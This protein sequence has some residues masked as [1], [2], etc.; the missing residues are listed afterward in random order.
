[1]AFPHDICNIICD[2]AAVYVVT[3][4]FIYHTEPD[5]HK[6]SGNTHTWAR[7]KLHANLK[8]I[9]WKYLSSNS[10]TWACD[11][12]KSN[13]EKIDW[14]FLSHNT[15]QWACD[16][17]RKNM[18]MVDFDHLEIATVV[19]KT[20]FDFHSELGD[21]KNIQFSWD[22]SYEPLVAIMKEI[23]EVTPEK[24]GWNELFANPHPW[25]IALAKENMESL[26]TSEYI[27]NPHPDVVKVLEVLV[28]AL[29]NIDRSEFK[30]GMLAINPNPQVLKIFSKYAQHKREEKYIW[31][32]PNIFMEDMDRRYYIKRILIHLNQPDHVYW[33]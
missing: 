1:M 16:H 3:Y 28:P 18:Q 22:S 8:R 7:D 6:L 12:L 25:A 29:I 23:A 20:S 30:W 31:W 2:Y 27:A 10:S 11:L 17:M 13:P 32:N 24:I 33:V 14:S 19:D 4:E 5:F 9:D 15:S 26:V 21:W